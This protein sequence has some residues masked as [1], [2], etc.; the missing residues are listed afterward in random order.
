MITAAKLVWVTA[1]IV[2]IIGAIII[3]F[4]LNRGHKTNN[5]SS[6]A[7]AQRLHQATP[8]AIVGYALLMFGIAFALTSME[9]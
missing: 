9:E 7:W 5:A 4:V 6:D 1:S 8:Y 3:R 2:S